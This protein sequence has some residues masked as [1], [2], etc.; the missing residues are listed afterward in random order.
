VLKFRNHA[1][2]QFAAQAIQAAAMLAPVQ[3]PYA[4]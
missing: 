4:A 1:E 3:Y 2:A